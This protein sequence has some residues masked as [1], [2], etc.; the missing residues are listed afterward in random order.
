MPRK[1]FSGKG[2]IPKSCLLGNSQETKK[3]N[4]A[5]RC[6]PAGH[7]LDRLLA[8]ARVDRKK[9]YVTNAMKHF[10]WEPRGKR[11]IHRKPRARGNCRRSSLA[12]CRD[13]CAQAH[14]DCLSGG[15]PGTSLLGRDFRVSQHRGEF[16]VSSLAP[17][18]MA[19]VHP[20][21][22]LRAPD[23]QT[24]HQ[25]EKEF[26]RDMAQIAKLKIGG[27]SLERRLFAWLTICLDVEIC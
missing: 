25:Q 27:S 22:S 21:S 8:Y 23:E 14:R 24:R 1:P 15:H 13:R 7:F 18:V 2:T 5:S 17:R 20:S 16:L 6:R 26:V 19:T 9:I 10:K 4:R 11:R 3:T 12:R